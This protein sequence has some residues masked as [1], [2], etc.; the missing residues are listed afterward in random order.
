MPALDNILQDPD[1]IGRVKAIT[2]ERYKAALRPFT[3]WAIQE[4][5][6]PTSPVEWDEALLD[7]RAVQCTTMTKAKFT[8]LVAALEFYQP[9]IKGRLVWCKT[10][11]SGWSRRTKIRHTTPMGSK[12]GTLVA[13]HMAA[14]GNPRM[15][16]GLMLQIRTGLRPGELLQLLPEHIVFPEDQ[17]V[18]DDTSP[19]IVALGAKAG[20]KAQRAQVAMIRPGEPHFWGA[21]KACRDSTPAGYFIFPCTMLAYRREIQAVEKLLGV[22]MKWGPHSPR[23]GYATDMK[24]KGASFEEIREGGRWLSDSSLRIYLDVIGATLVLRA[25]RS[26]GLASQIMA[27]ERLWPLYFGAQLPARSSR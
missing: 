23:A 17:G 15:G 10:V 18:W 21:L 9:P 2:L 7:Y 3:A 6:N 26:Q 22:S 4:G 14:R 5:L 8:T 20:T 1:F 19:I 16:L 25:M 12:P 11:L 24:L 27:A 13:I